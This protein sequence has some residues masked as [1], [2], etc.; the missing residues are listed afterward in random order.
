MTS[1]GR[2]GIRALPRIQQCPVCRPVIKRTPRRRTDGAAG[3]HI[4]E[5]HPSC[6]HLVQVRRPNDFLPVTAQVAVAQVIGQNKDDVRAFLTHCCCSLV[7]AQLG[8]REDT[9][10]EAA[11]KPTVLRNCLRDGSSIIVPLIY[12]ESNPAINCGAKHLPLYFCGCGIVMSISRTWPNADS[13]SS[14]SCGRP[15]AKICI[16][17]G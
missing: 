8:N 2:S 16:L 6:G 15:T 14:K 3:G 10:T 9:L 13:G 5:A 7:L 4:G 11:A 1:A 12:R 17:S